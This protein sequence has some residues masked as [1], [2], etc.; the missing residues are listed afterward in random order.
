MGNEKTNVT[1]TS[2]DG[3]TYEMKI[4][5]EDEEMGKLIEILNSKINDAHKKINILASNIIFFFIAGSLF[6]IAII[7][8]LLKG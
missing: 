3:P 8:L 6:G 7:Y 4:E 2:P 1:G 5:Y